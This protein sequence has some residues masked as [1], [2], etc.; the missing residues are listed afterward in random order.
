MLIN[1][2]G[3]LLINTINNNTPT[4]KNKLFIGIT[5]YKKDLQKKQD[6]IKKQKDN[7]INNYEQKRNEDKIN[8]DEY[9][10]NR[11]LLFNK[12]KKTKNPIDLQTLLSYKLPELYNVDNIYTYDIKKSNLK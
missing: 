4:N 11:N 1:N 12:W 3:L 9:L 8:Y 2:L 7:Y 5:N 10:H 6:F